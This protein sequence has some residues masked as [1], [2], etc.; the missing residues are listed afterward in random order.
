MTS[1]TVLKTKIFLPPLRSGVTPRPRLVRLIDEGIQ[2]KVLLVSAPA[3]FGKSTLLIEWAAQSR[4]PAAWV[5]LDR[6]EN[7]PV[8]FLSYLIASVQVIYPGL[9]D[10]SLGALRVPGSPSLDNL[11]NAWMNE[12]A[13]HTKE[14][15][16]IL[17]DFHHIREQSVIDLICSLTDH[18]PEQLHLILA[19]RSDLPLSCSR[20]RAKGELIEMGIGDLRFTLGETLSYLHSQLGARISDDDA[21]TLGSRTEGWIAGLQ[22]AVLTMR[23]SED[24]HQYVTQFSA[25]NR[26]V[27]DYLLDEVLQRQ[28]EEIKGFLLATSVLNKFTAPLCDCVVG[29]G[30]SQEIIENLERSGLFTIPLD[31]TRTWYRY[32]HLFAEFLRKRLAQSPV[33]SVELLRRRASDWFAVEGMLDECVEQALAIQDYDLVIRRI[34]ERLNQIVAQGLFRNYLAWVEKIPRRFLEQKPRLEVVKAFMLHEMGRL[35]ERDRQLALAALLLGELPADRE[36]CSP[37]ELINHGILAAIETI[38]YASGYFLVEDAVR[39][40]EQAERLLPEEYALWRALARGAI[41][42][43]QRAQGDYRQVIEGFQQ[44]LDLDLK[45]GFTFQTFVMYSALSKSYLETG[46]LKLAIIT[47]QKALDLDARQGASLPFARLAYIILGE[48][49]YQAGQ[50]DS[51]EYYIELGLEHIVRHGD[52]YS[53]LDGYFTLARIQLAQGDQ[54]QAVALIA[55]MKAAIRDLAPSRNALRLANAWEAYVMIATN[56]LDAVRD[57]VKDPASY[58]LDGK[59][60]FD[61]GSHTYVGVYRVSQ[62]PI[63][64]YVDAMRITLAR[65]YLAVNNLEQGIRTVDAVLQEVEKDGR[66][67]QQI[68][69]LLIKALLLQ[70][71]RREPEAYRSFSQAIHLAARDGFTQLFLNEGPQIKGLLEQAKQ[72]EG[73][74]L[75]EQ[76]FVWQLLE[77]Q[78]LA[79]ARQARGPALQPDQLTDRE[80]EVLK[81]LA[82]G[83]SY[84]SAAQELSISRNTLKTHTRR[85]YEKLGVS[86]LLQA[87]NKSREL[88]IL[89]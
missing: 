29:V 63:R 8:S 88:G 79:A 14:F 86:G 49:L 58:Q 16:L 42:F 11:L 56:R 38:V 62:S 19:S 23:T 65:F 67:N 78:Q 84:A 43:M 21:R 24:I 10:A 55:E 40:L 7:D 80:I 1:S 83:V 15:V 69:S 18:Q 74:D 34:E 47:C 51:A 44:V 57:W 37:G 72:S 75:E 52:V 87:L 64:I 45:I 70:K 68:E 13:E 33:F 85:I 22:M 50:L 9:G 20:I 61:L 82:G 54:E 53:I 35:E 3:G 36:A 59:Y 27:T 12:V 41:P 2:K 46:K 48:L 31:T 60:L 76:V 66:V 4:L 71:M 30:N 5:S 81:M 17:D 32:H 25:Q 28:P 89:K 77:R 26:Y 73:S 6:T 39:C